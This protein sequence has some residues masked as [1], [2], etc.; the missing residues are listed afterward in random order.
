[1]ERARTF[2][3]WWQGCLVRSSRSL[4]RPSSLARVSDMTKCL[5]P[6][7]GAQALTQGGTGQERVST[8]RRREVPCLSQRMR[9]GASISSS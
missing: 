8:A 1:M 4:T 5:G 7:Q 3:H 9:T 2:M 6:L